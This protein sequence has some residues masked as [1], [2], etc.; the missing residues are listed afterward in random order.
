MFRFLEPRK[1]GFTLIELLVVIAIIAVLIG[2]LLP[3]VQ[4]VREAAARAQCQNNMHQ[5]SLATINCAQ[6]NGDI[7]PPTNWSFYPNIQA[8][9][10]A[11]N[12]GWGGTFFFLFPYIEQQNTYNASLMT[13]GVPNNTGY[14]IN[15]T[16]GYNVP[17]Y[18]NWGNPLWASDQGTGSTPTIKTYICPSDPSTNQCSN[19]SVLSY[20]ANEAVVRSGGNFNRYPANITDGTSNTIFYTELEFYCY[21]ISSPQSPWNEIREASNFINNVDGGG[22]WPIG[23][24]CYPQFAPIV[25]N[26]NSSLPASG[27]TGGIVVA[28]GDGSA[29]M[30]AQG[31]SS[32]TWGAALSPASG[33]LLGPDW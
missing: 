7:L 22:G 10:N 27:H 31:I 2:L 20:A 26:C 32:T 12:N 28:L 11:A 17:L 21:G 1:R 19:C 13:P 33:D 16:F 30:V 8:G 6:V 15:G 9:G 14:T 5:L 3:A 18:T 23:A 29:R 24:A 4:K 25:G